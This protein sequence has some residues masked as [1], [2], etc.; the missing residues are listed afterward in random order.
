MHARNPTKNKNKKNIEKSSSLILEKVQI[1]TEVQI[2]EMKNLEF[3][4]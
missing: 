3:V 2:K 4:I 1:V